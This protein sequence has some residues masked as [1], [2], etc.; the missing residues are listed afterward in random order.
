ME[1]EGWI[2]LHRQ[3]LN[4]EWFDSLEMV[5]LFIFL[6]LEAN[7]EDRKWHGQTIQRGQ[8]LTSLEKLSEETRLTERKVR[9][10]LSRME[11]TGEIVKKTT[12]RYTL[13]TISNYDRYQVKEEPVRQTSDTLP[14]HERQTN[15][16]QTT[17][18]KNDKNV[19][20]KEDIIS[21][22]ELCPTE[23]SD[24]TPAQA[25]NDEEILTNRHCQNIVDFWNKTVTETNSTLP[26][27]LTLSDKRKKKMRIRWKEFSK[28]GDPVEVCRQ[29][30]TKACTSKFC[31][32]DNKS[33][34]SADFDWIFTN[35]ENWVKVYEGNYDNKPAV[36]GQVRGGPV[37]AQQKTRVEKAIETYNEVEQWIH[38][39]FSDTAGN[40][41]PDFQ[42]QQ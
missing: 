19:R 37:Q 34:W 11:Q 4:W 5:K 7:H 29:V 28:V 8:I 33:G 30:F 36:A 2:K 22:I 24:D 39:R 12:Q 25:D 13:L 41:T 38:E 42:S 20:M 26:Q 6:L 9:T 3:F 35:G 40:S 32:G 17:T 23:P 21:S 18:N 15:D 1:S 31:Q 10:C 16:E 14:T 27:V